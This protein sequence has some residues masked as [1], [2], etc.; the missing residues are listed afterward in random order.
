MVEMAQ[1]PVGVIGVGF[2]GA[3]WARA[4]AEHPG[5]WLAVVSD[6]REQIGREVA[7]RY[8]AA[9]VPDPL[10]AAADPR[11]DAVAVCTPEHLHVQPATTGLEAGHAVM[12]EKPL[13]DTVAAAEAIRDLADRRGVPVLVGHILRFEPRYAAIRRAVESGGLG[14]VQAVR[15]ERIGLVAD[16]RVLGGRTSVALYYGVHELD[17]CRW[18]AGEIETVWAAASAGVLETAGYQV[19]DLYSIG[20][21]FTSGAHGTSTVGWSLPGKTPGHG[22]AGFTVIGERGAA[23][24]TQGEVGILDVRQDGVHHHDVYYSPEIDGR[25]G[26]ALANE[27]DHF[28]RV[29]TGITQPLCTAADGAAAVRLALA[30][31]LAARNG[32]VVRP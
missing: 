30:A 5:A 23:R 16:Q 13:A 22:L 1:V 15:S 10:E 20:L 29:A 25:L 14:E 18:Y 32:E 31:E 9:F 19:D 26:G 17:L 8:G 3:R 11:L 27:V 7:D 12:V 28:V 6:I 4:L 2:M 24:V 21:R